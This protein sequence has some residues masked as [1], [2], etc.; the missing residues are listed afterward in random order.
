MIEVT[1]RRGHKW[2]IDN[3]DLPLFEQY[4]WG[5][6]NTGD[7]I[8][9]SRYDKLLMRR[10][11]FHREIMKATAD[12]IIDHIDRNTFNLQKINLRKCTLSDNNHNATRPLGKSGY[13]GVFQRNRPLPYV[14]RINLKGKQKYIG[15]YFTAIEAAKAW[16]K[17][18]FNNFGLSQTL[19]FPQDYA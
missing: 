4:G 6:H 17:V 15:Q 5:A 14:A 16:D 18:A 12:E 1:T 2:Q 11:Y 7:N 3:E 8:Y 10:Y 19:N 13:R 9:L